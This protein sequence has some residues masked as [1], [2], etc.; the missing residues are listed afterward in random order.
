MNIVHFVFL[1]VG[2]DAG[3]VRSC[4]RKAETSFGQSAQRSFARYTDFYH[5]YI[6]PREASGIMFLNFFKGS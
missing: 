4:S 6:Q 5:P 2:W 1:T 3:Y